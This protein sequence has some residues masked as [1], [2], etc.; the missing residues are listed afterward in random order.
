MIQRFVIPPTPHVTVAKVTW[1]DKVVTKEVLINETP[2]F[3]PKLYT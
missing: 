2:M 1:S 3:L